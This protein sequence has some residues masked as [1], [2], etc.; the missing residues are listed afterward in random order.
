M[1]FS[2]DAGVGERLPADARVLV[3]DDN[4]VSV[5]LVTE[6]L[7]R[8]GVEHVRG[9]TDSRQT[10][11]S[12]Q[13]FTPDLVVLDL[14]MPGH[15]GFAVLHEL[16]AEVADSEYLPILVLTADITVDARDRALRAGARDFLT[17]PFDRTELVLRVRNLLETRA[18]QQELDQ[19]NQGLRA[20]AHAQEERRERRAEE[21]RHR[22]NRIERL[23]AGEGLT[24]VFQPVVDLTDGR[25][26]GAEALARM[27]LEPTRPPDQWFAEAARLG[28][29]V[30]LE[31][32][33]VRAAL[34]GLDRLPPDATLAVNVSPATVLDPRLEVTLARVA[35]S[36]VS[37][38]VTEHARV[39][40]YDVLARALAGLRRDGVRLAVDDAGA[41]FASLQH[42][43]RL[44]PDVIKLD[45]SLTRDIDTDP[46][47][48]A[49]ATSLVRFATEMGA[50]IV[51]E[52]IETAT[53]LT[54]LRE[55]GVPLGQ[56]YHLQ[57]PGPL[58]VPE[59]VAIGA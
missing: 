58:P 6:V 4:A 30:D 52:G 34:A 57:R 54:A 32:A 8:A 2:A 39:E 12:Y 3:V 16:S 56:G 7:V 28:L 11:H 18:R 5:R 15:D 44:R 22:R 21:R 33:A 59:L 24:M 46:V 45:I 14:Q 35:A 48:R 26:T 49:L 1:P 47:R 23:M 17:K 20:E 37:L 9:L 41:G 50:T 19:E 42:I 27:A 43:L 25:V 55:L 38:E 10:L 13:Q 29:G 53:E 40:D 36:R 51:A 31:L